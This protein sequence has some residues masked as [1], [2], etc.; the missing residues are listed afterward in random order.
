MHSIALHCP[1]L[2]WK[3]PH[4]ISLAYKTMFTVLRKSSTLLKII[5]SMLA[6]KLLLDTEDQGRHNFESFFYYNIAYLNKGGHLT[7]DT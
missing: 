6:Q 4:S 3:Y 2:S 5:K 1:V 7:P